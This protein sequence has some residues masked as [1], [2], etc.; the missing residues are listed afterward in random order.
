[1]EAAPLALGASGTQ[2]HPHVIAPGPPQGSWAGSR[3]RGQLHTH[4]HSPYTHTYTHTVVMHMGSGTRLP[5]LFLSSL[6]D[7]KLSS[8]LSHLPPP[9][10][11]VLHQDNSQINALDQILISG[12]AFV[13]I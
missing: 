2:L 4:T 9:S 11:T 6:W 5:T 1:M 7:P 3:R 10:L 12:S 8:S 13:G